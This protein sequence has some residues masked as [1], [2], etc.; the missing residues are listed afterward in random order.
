MKLELSKRGEKLDTKDNDQAPD[1]RQPLSPLLRV[2][3][4]DEGNLEWV[5]IQ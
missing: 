5:R 1:F 2:A 4:N 3:R